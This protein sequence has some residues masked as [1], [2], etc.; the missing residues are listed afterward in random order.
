VELLQALYGTLKVALLFWNKIWKKLVATLRE[1]G[2]E[3]N[4]Y[5][6]CVAN[7]MINGK[8]CTVLWHVDDLKISHVEYGVVSSIIE[9]ISG[10]F[11]K[12][13]PMTETRGKTHEYLGMTLDFS[14]V[15]K[16]KIYMTDYI[17]NVL[18]GAPTDMDGVAATPAPNHLFT[19]NVDNPIKLD[20]KTATVFH[21]IVAQLLFLCK[22]A[23]PDIQRAVSLLCTRV[24]SPDTDDCKKLERVVRYLRGIIDM[25]LTLEAD[26]PN[27]VKWWVDASFATHPD[28]KGHTGAALSLGKSVIYWE[29]TKQKLN[30]RS[31]T[32]SELVGIHDVLPQI[33]WTQHFLKAQGYDDV[34]YTVY[35][36]NQ[37]TMLLANNG[38]A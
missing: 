10:E 18:G 3:T 4:P 37:S 30:T 23:C 15:G 22:R 19:I 35:Q 26:N 7:K 17:T 32:E 38:R 14:C 6:W 28:M 31:S 11:G 1:W 34:V 9:L 33:L 20:E 2:F 16:A 25:P 29:S 8:H 12:D 24:K 21:H 36:D 13:A 27:I 5:D